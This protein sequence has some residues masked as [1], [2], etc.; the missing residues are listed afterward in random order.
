MACQVKSSGASL[1]LPMPFLEVDDGCCHGTFHCVPWMRFGL[2]LL[3]GLAPRFLQVWEL[4]RWPGLDKA[5][6]SPDVVDDD[7]ICWVKITV[8]AQMI[9]AAQESTSAPVQCLT[10]GCAVSWSKSLAFNSPHGNWLDSGSLMVNT[11][12]PHHR[13]NRRFIFMEEFTHLSIGVPVKAGDEV[14]IVGLA[15]QTRDPL[16]LGFPG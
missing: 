10:Q 3:L 15:G 13:C 7:L 16:P 9:G 14:L 5:V 11:K 2:E 8:A 6:E 12:I 4:V 1:D